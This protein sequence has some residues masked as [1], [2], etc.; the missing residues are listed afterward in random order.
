MRL[1]VCLTHF[2]R[3]DRLGATLESL[4]AQ[5]VR[6]D[7][8]LVWDDASPGDPAAVVATFR[9]AF[10]RLVFHRNPRNLGM[11]GNLNA[12]LAEARGRYI[13][14][15]H[16]ADR[17]HPTLLE[18][19]AGA[20]DANPTAGF[21]FCRVGG[22]NAA[23]ERRLVGCA[24]LV[25]GLEFY[26]RYFLNS[27]RGSSPVWGTVM[28]RRTVYE[29]LLPFDA[30]FGAVADVDMWMRCCFVADVAFVDAALIETDTG[31]HFVRGVNWGLVHALRR[32]HSTN[33]ARYAARTDRPV[34]PLWL[35]HRIN[36]GCLHALGVASLVRR[37]RWSELT[38][39]WREARVRPEAASIPR[40]A[41]H[42]R[43]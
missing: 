3:V 1:S 9:G 7:E 37:G 31:S 30:Q 6:P 21:A 34:W 17:F 42:V 15:L 22:R 29:Q 19:W 18:R 33:L 12:V 23:Q 27:W 38:G 25:P 41:F 20:L 11:P 4:A 16:D 40:P 13:A 8:V 2:D 24:P 28:A 39:A 26:R 10:P 5:T 36:F 43:G 32:L 14:N 35:R